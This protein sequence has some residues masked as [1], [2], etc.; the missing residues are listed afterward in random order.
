M[1]DTIG[2]LNGIIQRR[3]T[4]AKKNKENSAVGQTCLK[5]EG[6]NQKIMMTHHK[7]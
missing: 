1:Q 4:F 5:K 3:I 6:N 7:K 2:Y